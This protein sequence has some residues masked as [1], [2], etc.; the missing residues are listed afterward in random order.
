MKYLVFLLLPSMAQAGRVVSESVPTTNAVVYIDTT[1]KHLDLSTSSYSGTVANVSL[2][3]SS[4]SVWSN[5]N[6]DRVVIYATGTIL[7][8]GVSVSTQQG[9]PFLSTLTATGVSPGTYGNTTNVG[10]F[11]VGADGRITAASNV[12]VAGSNTNISSQTFTNSVSIT[13]GLSVGN[14]S[15]SYGGGQGTTSVWMKSIDGGTTSSGCVVAVSA[16]TN[17]APY[18]L[19]FTS[20]N[21]TVNPVHIGV[22]KTPSCTGGGFC[23]IFM[24]GPVSVV[25]SNIAVYGNLIGTSGATRCY[26][27]NNG[28]T[29]TGSNGTVI[30]GNSGAGQHAIVFLSGGH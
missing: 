19:Q 29:G 27:S 10:Q 20:T 15:A 25:T 8:N 3:S 28:G 23:E 12:S 26:G 17:E 5:D 7:L 22:Q 21:T 24:W 13:D 18:L 14:S 11:T 16:S 30:A 9:G 2:F 6:R 4:N 1:N